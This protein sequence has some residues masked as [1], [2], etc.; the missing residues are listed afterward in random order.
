MFQKDT[1]QIYSCQPSISVF[2]LLAWID[3]FARLYIFLLVLFIRVV[4]DFFFHTEGKYESFNK[5]SHSSPLSSGSEEC[6]KLWKNSARLLLL[7]W[8]NSTLF[9]YLFIL[10]SPDS[11]HWWMGSGNITGKW[12]KTCLSS[13]SITSPV[14][15]QT[16]WKCHS[17]LWHKDTVYFP[18]S[19]GISL[20][21]AMCTHS[22]THTHPS[23]T[24]CLHMSIDWQSADT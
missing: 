2:I 14:S 6:S 18:I 19:F 10:S 11:S 21:Y 1:L 8:F 15:I 22:C 20:E 17:P 9:I 24:G 7:E 13:H 23:F 5:L 16:T 12:S 3:V 4:Q